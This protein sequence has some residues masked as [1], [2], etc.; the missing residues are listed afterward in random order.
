[1]TN[2]YT[3]MFLD[4]TGLPRAWGSAPTKED[5]TLEAQRQLEVYCARRREVDDIPEMCSPSHY[6]LVIDL[7]GVS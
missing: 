5:A 7:E 6:S 3:A 4:F 2:R 1:M